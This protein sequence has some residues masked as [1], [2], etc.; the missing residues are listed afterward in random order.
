MRSG[1]KGAGVRNGPHDVVG[2]RAPCQ[3]DLRVGGDAHAASDLEDP[4][5][6]GAA[7][8]GA[9]GGETDVGPE[10]VEAG[11]KGLSPEDAGVQ[12]DEVGIDAAGGVGVG[13]LHVR[14]GSCHLGRSGNL[15]VGGVHVA[16]DLVRG[17]EGAARV[18]DE[19]EAGQRIPRDGGHADVAG[20]DRLRHGAHARFGEDSKVSGGAE[21]DG[22]RHHCVS[23][24]RRGGMGEIS[25]AM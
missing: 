16:R 12:L 13:G 5:V 20:D 19:A 7:V 3:G 14:D 15:H 1:A 25:C 4:R 6:G 17:G 22:S 2:E 8:E 11:G 23:G 18:Q 21:V 9:I 10:L 24:A